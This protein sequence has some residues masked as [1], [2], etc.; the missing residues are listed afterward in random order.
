MDL[1]KLSEL[2]VEALRELGNIGVGHAA[3]SL[4][5]LLGKTVEMNVPRVEITEISRVHEVI[6][7]DKV[8]AG[9]VAG[10]NDIDKG[11][12]GYLYIVFPDS[13][14][15]KIAEIM[16]IEE[17]MIESALTE[18]GNILSSS[19]CNATAEM[20]GAILMPTPPDFAR[21]Y[22]MAIIDALLAQ[23]VAKWDRVI[24]FDTQLKDE[25]Q[26]VNIEVILI[27][28]EGLMEYIKKLVDMVE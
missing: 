21:D 5:Q 9:V 23:L 2:E 28:S 18:I 6:K 3:T 11:L 10:L 16:M 22:L 20:L 24:I 13:A 26:S 8:V 1:S 19:F 25:S 12:A 7:A 27:P 15:K 17:D 14:E 4:S